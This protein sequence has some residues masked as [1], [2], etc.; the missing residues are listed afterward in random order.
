MNTTISDQDMTYDGQWPEPLRDEPK[1]V[2]FPTNALLRWFIPGIIGFI[3]LSVILSI[4][5]QEASK[6]IGTSPISVPNVNCAKKANP[7]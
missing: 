5:S 2:P 7:V 3:L 6:K 4:L 1:I